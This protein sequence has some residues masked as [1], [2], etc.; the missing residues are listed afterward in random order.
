M[1]SP[2]PTR[3]QLIGAEGDGI[4][5]ELCVCG[6]ERVGGTDLVD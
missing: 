5:D 2:T 6:N 3:I 4:A 1:G